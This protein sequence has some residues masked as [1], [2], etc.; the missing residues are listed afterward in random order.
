MGDAALIRQAYRYA[1]DPTVEQEALLRSFTGASRFWFNQGL[2][3]VKERLAARARGEDVRVPWSY[4][5]LC[6][7]F[8]GDAVKD[9]LAPWRSE[10]PVGAYQAGLE[11]LGRALQN[12]SQGRR[13]G[14]RVGFPASVQRVV[15]AS[16]SSSSA[17][18]SARHVRSISTT[19]SAR[20]ARRSG[21]RS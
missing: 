8:K 4:K 19:E 15:A 9:E 12:F 5:A 11:M 6:S 16:R 21:C 17:R 10:V 3:L 7:E 2:A 18:G 1:L 20:S 14:R 13:A